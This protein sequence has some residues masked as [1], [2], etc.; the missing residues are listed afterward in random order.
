M[1]ELPTG[2][3]SDR[4]HNH[5]Y[6]FGG[7]M[8]LLGNILDSEGLLDIRVLKDKHEFGEKLSN[9]WETLV[10]TNIPVTRL[11]FTDTRQIDSV[12]NKLQLIKDKMKRDEK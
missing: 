12:I 5:F 11:I 4:E 2:F 3:Y 7:K 10:D 9:D 6:V 8:L 1:K